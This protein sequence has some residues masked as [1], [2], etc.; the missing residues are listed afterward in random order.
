MDAALMLTKGAHNGSAQ[1][2]LNPSLGSKL[3]RLLKL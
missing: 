2:A 1:A 3:S